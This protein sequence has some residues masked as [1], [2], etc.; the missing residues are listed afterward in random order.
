MRKARIVAIVVAGVLTLACIVSCFYVVRVTGYGYFAAF[1]GGSLEVGTR[2]PVTAAIP[3]RV[4]IWRSEFLFHCFPL[5]T[6]IKR[7]GRSSPIYWISLWPLPLV[8]WLTS[9]V[10]TYRMRRR[11]KIPGTMCRCGYDLKGNESGTCPECGDPVTLASHDR[12]VTSSGNAVDDQRQ[13]HHGQ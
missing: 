11:S 3:G 13:H 2:S 9:I 5:V 8:T 7:I 12:D 6:K 1:G 4:K 10:I